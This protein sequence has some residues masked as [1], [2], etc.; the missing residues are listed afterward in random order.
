L[1]CKFIVII[2]IFIYSYERLNSF[3]KKVGYWKIDGSSI[4]YAFTINEGKL[5]ASKSFS[6]IET[7]WISLKF[8]EEINEKEIVSYEIDDKSQPGINSSFCTKS[9]LKKSIQRYLLPENGERK[10]IEEGCLNL[11][12]FPIYLI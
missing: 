10:Q 11:L 12:I 7:D 6:I 2:E 5:V 8:H 3:I 4:Y 1:V 9:L